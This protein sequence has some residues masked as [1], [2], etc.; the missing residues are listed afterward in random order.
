MEEYKRRLELFSHYDHTNIEKHLEKMASKGWMIDSIGSTFWRYKKTEPKKLRFSVVYYPKEVKEGTVISADRQNFIDLCS[1][2]GWNYLINSGKMHIFATDD[3]TAPPI[4]TDAAIQI[5]C[6][7]K[8]AK[9]EIVYGYLFLASVCLAISAYG[10]YKL[11]KAPVDTLT[12]IEFRFWCTPLFFI[13]SVINIITYLLWYKK[14]K[15]AA[16]NGEF[17]DT[18]KIISFEVMYWFPMYVGFGFLGVLSFIR[19]RDI[20][21]ILGLITL[22]VLL[23]II[24][25]KIK[26]IIFNSERSEISKLRLKRFA[27]VMLVFAWAGAG[28]GAYIAIPKPYYKVK[29]KSEFSNNVISEKVYTDNDAPIDFSD[30]GVTTDK[31][32]SREKNSREFLLIK[33]NEWYIHTVDDSEEDGLF[34]RYTVTDVRFAPILEKCKDELI[35]NSEIFNYKETDIG[36]SETDG[37]KFFVDDDTEIKYYAF[38]RDNRI[39]SIRFGWNVTEEQLIDIAGKIMNSESSYAF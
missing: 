9:A 8:F 22:A 6:I 13:F 38:Y 36:T 28:I 16:E 29:V 1:S 19:I 32:V 11:W 17:T 4:D 5:E 24:F 10:I 21:F 37:C 39:V 15:A 26:S 35:Y 3:E 20:L 27:A 2:G 7:H 18:K 34:L 30:F 25:K 23:F 31:T 12:D 33:E 14:A